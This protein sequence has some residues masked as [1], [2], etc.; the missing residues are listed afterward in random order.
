MTNKLTLKEVK[1][2]SLSSRTKEYLRALLN[3][4]KAKDFLKKI[5]TKTAYTY[6]LSDLPNIDFIDSVNDPEAAANEIVN[7]YRF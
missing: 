3:T 5:T 1:N 7:V 2:K 6:I 4:E